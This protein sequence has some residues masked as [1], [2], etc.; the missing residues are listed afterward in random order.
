MLAVRQFL[1]LAGIAGLLLW[2]DREAQA[3]DLDHEAGLQ[4]LAE[5]HPADAAALEFGMIQG[6]EVTRFLQESTAARKLRG[7]YGG[8]A[9]QY[10]GE[11]WLERRKDGDRFWLM[12]AY[13]VAVDLEEPKPGAATSVE[14]ALVAKFEARDPVEYS[15]RLIEALVASSGQRGL[16]DSGQGPPLLWHAALTH[17]NGSRL[18]AIKLADAIMVNANGQQVELVLASAV[19]I[20]SEVLYLEA[21]RAYQETGDLAAFT[22]A[23]EAILARFE[24]STYW[25]GAFEILL[26]NLRNPQ[27]PAGPEHP[28][29]SA[30]IAEQET[31]GTVQLLSRL[32]HQFWLYEP[33]LLL[34]K[35][36]NI[37]SPL[38]GVVLKG[39]EGLRELLPLLRDRR[40]TPILDAQGGVSDALNSHFHDLAYFYGVDQ[41]GEAER[42]FQQLPHP[43]SV[44][45]VAGRLVDPFLDYQQQALPPEE[46]A[47]VIEAWLTRVEGKSDEEVVLAILADSSQDQLQQSLSMTLAQMPGEKGLPL[48][49]KSIR[50]SEINFPMLMMAQQ[51]MQRRPQVASQLAEALAEREFDPDAIVAQ[52]DAQY[53]GGSTE[54]LE[55]QMQMLMATLDAHREPVDAETFFKEIAGEE[56]ADPGAYRVKWHRILSEADL[57]ELVAWWK[58]AVQTTESIEGRV[59]LLSLAT[60]GYQEPEAHQAFRRAVAGDE[61]FW[62]EIDQDERLI[63]QESV[64]LTIQNLGR[65][66]RWTSGWEDGRPFTPESFMGGGQRWAD[67]MLEQL[68]AQLAGETLDPF[69]PETLPESTKLVAEAK[70]RTGEA[71]A[72]FLA[73]LQ[74]GE[75]AALQAAAEEDAELRAHLS[76][77]LDQIDTIVP[78]AEPGWAVTLAP[79]EKAFFEVLS[80]NAGPDAVKTGFLFL[81]IIS[82][83]P[84]S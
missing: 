57:E 60:P 78:A 77:I 59:K 48:M 69:L 71:L 58:V 68:P 80:E 8:F 51:W 67:W 24:G 30:L 53:G 5:A 44:A 36:G 40:L 81:R 22:S 16:L 39:R 10:E 46:K 31:E 21:L 74:P 84:E 62:V 25:E 54:Y 45:E 63:P 43:L 79:F 17:A 61:A 73:G 72:E 38:T 52:Q 83:P 11:G 82:P 14:G 26:A 12:G 29:A 33:E 50:T 65:W 66:I 27:S 70:E 3:V 1:A 47:A 6:E 49:L 41:E 7:Q 13:P 23:V 42:R 55:G 20:L 19:N 28:V 32:N 4:A 75:A 9:V 76:P 64:A 2:T 15:D 56:D 18:A 34:Q 37:E 35:L